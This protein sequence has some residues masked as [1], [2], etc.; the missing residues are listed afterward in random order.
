VIT[1]GKWD[2]VGWV[3]VGI[4]L[5]ATFTASKKNP[6]YLRLEDRITPH[7]PIVRKNAIQIVSSHSGSYHAEQ[8]FDI[9]DYMRNLNYVDD[10]YP[11]HI[12][13]PKDTLEAGGGDCDDFAVTTA[14]LIEAIGGTARVVTVTDNI[15]GHAFCE[16]YIGKEGSMKPIIPIIQRRY[17]HVSI[18]WEYDSGGE[19]F[20][21][22]TLLPTPGLLYSDFVII[23]ENT[24]NWRPDII[25]KNYCAH[26]S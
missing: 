14:S 12:A 7:D 24:W 5:G 1:L 17:G 26:D 9:F 13:L 3:G 4:V 16:V 20:L 22:D 21:F 10:P 18:A 6:E 8:L 15:L 11:D 2:W 25:R 19:W 23:S